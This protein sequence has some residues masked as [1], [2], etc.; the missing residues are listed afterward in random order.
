MQSQSSSNSNLSKKRMEEEIISDQLY[1][2]GEGVRRSSEGDA[3]QAFKDVR[4][5]Q[6]DQGEPI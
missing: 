1:R 6:R 5:H 3:T 2:A 4:S